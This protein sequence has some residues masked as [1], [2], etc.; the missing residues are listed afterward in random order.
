M[1]LVYLHRGSRWCIL[2]SAYPGGR[3]GTL[4]LDHVDYGLALIAT[5]VPTQVCPACAR[6]LVAGTPGA[7]TAVEPSRCMTRDLRG[8][9]DRSSDDLAV[10]IERDPDSAWQEWFLGEAR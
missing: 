7:A 4:C 5:L 3:I 9:R 10:P 1:T 2:R 6:E 8:P